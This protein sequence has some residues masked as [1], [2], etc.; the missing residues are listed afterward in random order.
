MSNPTVINSD[1]DKDIDEQIEK[2]YDDYDEVQR[3]YEM[4]GDE[5]ARGTI[6]GKEAGELY[7]LMDSSD[8]PGWI[9]KLKAKM[10][11]KPDVIVQYAINGGGYSPT[12]STV[13][14]LPAGVY[15]IGYVNKMLT[16]L[17][18]PLRT[19][20]LI[21]FP[22]TKSDMIIEQIKKFWEL[23]SKF[24]DYGFL[25]KRGILLWGTPGMGKTGLIS[26]IIQDMTERGG[27]VIIV[28][29]GA[30]TVASGLRALREVEPNRPC[31]VVMEDLD[32]LIKRHNEADFLSLMDGEH[33]VDNVVFIATTNYP[34]LL[35]KRLTN[36]P[37]RFDLLVEI[38]PP[39]DEARKL[40]FQ[41]KLKA[42]DHYNIEE[43][44]AS[45]KNFSFAHL[46]ELIVSVIC[47]GNKLEDE[48]ARLKGMIKKQPKSSDTG[49]SMGLS[50]KFD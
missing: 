32:E 26:L 39:N 44:V 23:K 25:H 38:D 30:D 28:T 33:Q 1:E 12:S 43:L 20:N 5:H 22:D 13:L 2:D 29:S 27:I 49:T 10:S 42:E 17:P 15:S 11:I 48:I 14:K 21:K 8:G 3:A 7:E 45:T 34:E 47:L 41:T 36:R 37:S 18:Q 19:D 46:K 40:Y 24:K 31:V 9:E 16:F 50:K 6:D 4:I 35:D